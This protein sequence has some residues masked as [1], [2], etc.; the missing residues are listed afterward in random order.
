MAA[1]EEW[2]CDWAEGGSEMGGRSCWARGGR[3]AARE[4]AGRARGR[5]AERERRSGLR[6]L[7][8]AVT[9]KVGWALAG[10]SL[11]TGR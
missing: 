3:W 4:V 1:G 11:E 8:W 7:G 6:C 10:L 5:W 9:F 2:A